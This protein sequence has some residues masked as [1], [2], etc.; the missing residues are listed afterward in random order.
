MDL[1]LRGEG[2]KGRLPRAP[3]VR[4]PQISDGILFTV[5]IYRLHPLLIHWCIQNAITPSWPCVNPVVVYHSAF[6]DDLICIRQVAQWRIYDKSCMVSWPASIY[7]MQ[8]VCY[9]FGCPTSSH[10]DAGDV[11]SHLP[12]WKNLRKVQVCYM[13]P[14]PI[15]L[16]VG[17]CNK[18]DEFVVKYPKHCKVSF[19]IIS[20]THT[21]TTRDGSTSSTQ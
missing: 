9:V 1:G 18:L 3:S 19:P 13:N 6:G 15:L 12:K 8:R 11:A 4:G 2:Q 7:W 20:F 17:S 5:N 21:M 14:V 10:A 16:S